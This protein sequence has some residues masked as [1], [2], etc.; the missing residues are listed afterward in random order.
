MN[1]L[2]SSKHLEGISDLTLTAPVKQGFIHSTESVTYETRL[3]LVARL[4]TR[5]KQEWFRDILAAGVPCGPINTIDA[6]VAFATE[7]GLDPAVEVGPEGRAV[8]SVRH[9]I[10]LAEN[11][12]G[13]RLPPPELDEHGAEIRAWLAE[14]DR[15]EAAHR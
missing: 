11:P 3:R 14:P 4:G 13:Y 7:I 2:I 6:G 1:K 15:A 8:P 12:A 9:P 5:T 10:T